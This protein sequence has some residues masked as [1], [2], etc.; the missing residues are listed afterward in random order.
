MHYDKKDF[1]CHSF[2]IFFPNISIQKAL[3]KQICVDNTFNDTPKLAQP[4]RRPI[5]SCATKVPAE[6]TTHVKCET[7]H[8]HRFKF[9]ETY[10]SKNGNIQT[11]RR[12]KEKGER[13]DRPLF[14][15]YCSMWWRDGGVF[16]ADINI[17]FLGTVRLAQRGPSTGKLQ[18]KFSKPQGRGIK[19]PRFRDL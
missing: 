13:S 18:R 12:A 11:E 17:N 15:K 10:M 3:G 1:I 9:S 4:M 7:P 5:E 8:K 14:E 2:V 19:E 6:T 16:I